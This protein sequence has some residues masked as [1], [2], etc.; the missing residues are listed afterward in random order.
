LATSPSDWAY[1]SLIAP[2]VLVL[3]IRLGGVFKRDG[4]GQLPNLHPGAK[5][6]F[7]T[8]LWQLGL[9]VLVLPVGL[10]GVFKRDGSGQLPNL[11]CN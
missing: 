4:S 8:E 9:F 6:K 5:L 7:R 2:F 11:G 3:P 1:S 10:G